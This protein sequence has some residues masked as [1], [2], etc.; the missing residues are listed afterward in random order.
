MPQRNFRPEHRPDES[1]IPEGGGEER[2]AKQHAADLFSI[3]DEALI[4]TIKTIRRVA[5]AIDATLPLQGLNL[6]QCNGEAAGQSVFHFHMHLIPREIGD[7][8][9]MNWEI[10]P[11]DMQAMEALAEK[12]RTK[13]D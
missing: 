10:V 4:A 6:F 2:I 9:K 7:D 8:M 5:K 12:I 3:D 1:S 13:L 11:G